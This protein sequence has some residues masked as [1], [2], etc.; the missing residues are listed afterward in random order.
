MPKKASL[1]IKIEP[2]V[3]EKAEQVLKEIGMS[4]TEAINLFYKQ[5]TL[6]KSFLLEIKLPLKKVNKEFAKEYFDKELFNLPVW[7]EEDIKEIEK[8]RKYINK[9]TIQEF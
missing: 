8:A 3:K 7:E 5:I 6:N 9:W 1:N 2:E 4:P